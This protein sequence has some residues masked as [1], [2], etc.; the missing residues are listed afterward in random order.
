[1]KTILGIDNGLHGA[2]S[3]YDGNEL[4]VYDMPT[5]KIDAR[6]VLNSPRILEI[7]ETH[8][9]AMVFLEKTTPLPKVSGLTAYSMGNSEGFMIGL[10][11]AL[12][13]PF[14]LVRPTNWK[15]AMQCPKDKDG[16]RMRASQLFPAFA[17][18]W[19]LKKHHDRAE[20]ALIALYGYRN[21]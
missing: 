20:S 19:D 11:T 6:L 3:F 18:N 8:K 17:H 4:L 13:I 21:T 1:M 5:Y 15:A 2:M 12:R 16:A 14:T 7:M 9:P 10:F